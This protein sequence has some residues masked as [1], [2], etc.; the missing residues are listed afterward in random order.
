MN[1]LQNGLNRDIST[2]KTAWDFSA[3]GKGG[4]QCADWPVNSGQQ[5]ICCVRLLTGYILEH[6]PSSPLGAASRPST[7][8]APPLLGGPFLVTSQW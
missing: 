1:V 8:R 4:M 6:C 2:V 3:R 5:G 7:H